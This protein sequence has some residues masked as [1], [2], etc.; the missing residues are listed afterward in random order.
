MSTVTTT[1]S[2]SLGSHAALYGGRRQAMPGSA[3]NAVEPG[4]RGPSPLSNSSTLN[5]WMFD[6]IGVGPDDFLGGSLQ[7]LPSI[8]GPGASTRQPDGQGSLQHRPG[9]SS[10][11]E[12]LGR[13][14]L[15]DDMF[16]SSVPSGLPYVDDY[17]LGAGTP[18]LESPNDA[19]A[20]QISP[21]E[22]GGQ[23]G[24]LALEVKEVRRV[25]LVVDDQQPPT[26][27]AR[28]SR[29]SIEEKAALEYV[30]GGMP[31]AWRR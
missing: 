31:H 6:A 12:G 29:L 9:Q 17:S 27:L 4:V 11:E 24:D 5:S 23:P 7:A 13:G 18:A 21:V 8:D 26:K 2:R 28:V 20:V 14:S 16:P 1:Q 22:L 19:P 30:F 25:R 3:S 15:F 10:L